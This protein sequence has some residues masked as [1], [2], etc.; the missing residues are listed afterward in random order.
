MRLRMSDSLIFPGQIPLGSFVRLFAPEV[1]WTMGRACEIHKVDD[2][3]TF[4]HRYAIAV[5]LSSQG[6][7]P[8][9]HKLTA[10]RYASY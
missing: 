6:F 10:G 7:N 8:H 3:R 9:L 2:P 5:S 1:Y 4:R